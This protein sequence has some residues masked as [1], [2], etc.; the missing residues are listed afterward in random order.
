M[1][2][3]SNV[4]RNGRI[5]PSLSEG[6]RAIQI[7][8]K[9]DAIA[10]KHVKM[11]ARPP[12]RIG[13]YNG[14]GFSTYTAPLGVG[15][16][17]PMRDKDLG[18]MIAD[19]VPTTEAV[20][21]PGSLY[22]DVKEELIDEE[23]MQA[24]NYN[25]YVSK[26]P[27]NSDRLD[28]RISKE[29]S[30]NGRL[31]LTNLAATVLHM[32]NMRENPF[33][34]R[35]AWWVNVEHG[36]QVPVRQEQSDVSVDKDTLAPSRYQMLLNGALL[37]EMHEL[38]RRRRMWMV[39]LEVFE[40]LFINPLTR[41]KK[42]KA[43]L[44]LINQSA[45]AMSTTGRWTSYGRV[46]SGNTMFSRSN[47]VI[48]KANQYTPDAGYWQIAQPY[49]REM[50][51]ETL[52]AKLVLFTNWSKALVKADINVT[53]L[54]DLHL[55]N[56][57][58][59]L[60]GY[61]GTDAVATFVTDFDPN[62][63]NADRPMDTYLYTEFKKIWETARTEK[64][65]P[66]PG[67]FAAAV[68]SILTS[69]SSGVEKAS[70][71]VK[72]RLARAG[73]D[74]LLISGKSKALVVL[75]RPEEA[76]VE[77][78]RSYTEENPGT[79]GTRNVPGLRA[80]RAIFSLT[81]ANFVWEYLLQ[82]TMFRVM[83]KKDK[84]D[85]PIGNSSYSFTHATGISDHIS[86]LIASADEY[87]LGV[88]ADYAEFDK[89]F[90][91]HKREILIKAF[92]DWCDETLQTGT[93]FGTRDLGVIPDIKDYLR[94]IWGERKRKN[95]AFAYKY[96]DE[97]K[98]FATDRLL[99]GEFV[100]SLLGSFVNR[101][102]FMSFLS[103]VDSDATPMARATK[104]L[105]AEF[106]GDDVKSQYSLTA[107]SQEKD[108]TPYLV[109]TFSQNADANQTSINILKSFSRKH[110]G[111]YLRNRTFFG[112]FMPGAITQTLGSE[113]GRAD[114][115]VI[116]IMSGW[117]SIVQLN[118]QRGW[119]PN[120]ATEFVYTTW[121]LLRSSKTSISG[122]RY[123]L[124]FALIWAPRSMGGIGFVHNNWV[125]ASRDSY[126]YN[127]MLNDERF[128]ELIKTAAGVFA[129]DKSSPVKD[130]LI[131]SINKGF[132][133]PEN[134]L[135]KGISF[136]LNSLDKASLKQMPSIREKL[137]EEG[138]PPLGDLAYD[139]LHVA[140]IEKAISG[141]Q[142]FKDAIGRDFIIRSSKA[143]LAASRGS[144]TLAKIPKSV[145]AFAMIN[146]ELADFLEP[147]CDIRTPTN[148]FSL[149][150]GPLMHLTTYYGLNSGENHLFRVEDHLARRLR[151]SSTMRRDVE[152]DTILS[153]L[154]A[155]GYY[156]NVQ[157]MA[158]FFAGLG[159]TYPEAVSLANDFAS[160]ATSHILYSATKGTSFN[161]QILPMIDFSNENIDRIV[162][163]PALP[164]NISRAL[165]TYGVMISLCHYSRT[166][167]AR[168]VVVSVKPGQENELYS[169]I[170]N[171]HLPLTR[172]L[173][174]YLFDQIADIP[175]TR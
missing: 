29:L 157:N 35:F 41:T 85:D 116:S 52:E 162:E 26:Y 8:S 108:L 86:E 76:R 25:E 27:H 151:Q 152:V 136:V 30:I 147:W 118:V 60:C 68:P 44:T 16:K 20:I 62:E 112:I 155:P 166:G 7:V 141:T 45:F 89:T 170:S 61:A 71:S 107:P 39:Y 161:D 78:V 37:F 87:S 73:T 100:T 130:D 174:G 138:L 80:T 69:K 74:D 124:P 23:L 58:V 172:H 66:T 34:R 129:E 40:W 125:G 117:I 91:S 142:A 115:D 128:D 154:R 33:I 96:V 42:I 84:S 46:S 113:K 110:S 4:V 48:S 98:V 50:N 17:E 127:L 120:K 140:V 75:L 63:P 1:D 126:I 144:I 19:V 158:L 95:A 167:E 65:I 56:T 121:N 105:Y 57:L 6:E 21:V 32:D 59:G 164:D 81:V 134:A 24:F 132:I 153:I 18:K 168:K 114:E 111:D 90:K 145:G 15:G 53:N 49:Y 94:T 92:E 72:T 171:N 99:S 82:E 149:C 103:R 14:N 83:S 11:G 131:G 3:K 5:A 135:E 139:R 13:Q 28:F 156:G 173:P 133:T 47:M 160:S 12:D 79:L 109:N 163:L 123:Y 159:A 119:E 2:V 51:N 169:A 31:R 77:K 106:M 38:A 36:G 101:T 143:M 54:S 175:R 70:L 22:V 104:L 88:F 165:V 10:I 122:T 137:A 150:R 55:M 43:W 9:Y 97:T 93:P 146:F 102:M 148:P 64:L 67:Q